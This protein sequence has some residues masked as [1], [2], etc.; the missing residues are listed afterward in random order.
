MKSE[1]ISVTEEEV[2]ETE[3]VD[4]DSSDKVERIKKAATA[5][6]LDSSIE[7][8]KSERKYKIYRPKEPLKLFLAKKTLNHRLDLR[9]IQ[10]DC[11]K[12]LPK[13]KLREEIF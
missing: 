10:L 4:V 7:G 6:R 1:E 8:V 12:S 13:R 2:P 9:L 3:Q 5:Y 11:L